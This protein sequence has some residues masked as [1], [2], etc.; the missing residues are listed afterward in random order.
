MG[1]NIFQKTYAHLKRRNKKMLIN[2]S[3]STPN[4]KQEKIR[5]GQSYLYQT[6]GMES[7]V[8]E[9]VFYKKVSGSALNQ[10][11]LETLKRYPYLNTKLVEL[12]G[13][14]YI[15]QNEMSITA[16][17]T[18]KLAKL[19]HISCGYHLIDITYFDKTVYVSW[20]HALCDGKGIKPFIE[21][22]VYYYCKFKYRSKASAEN[23]RLS[24]SK[25]L[26]GETTEPNLNGYDYD[27]NKDTVQISRDAYAIPENIIEEHEVDYRY[28][29]DIPAN[30]FM[31]VCKENHATPVIL[32]SLLTSA[33]IATLYPDFDKPINANIAVDIREA[34]D[35]PNTFKNCVRSM[36][37]PFDRTF[38]TMSLQEQAEKQRALLNAQRDRDNCRKQANASLG[39]YEKLDSLPDYKEKQKV[40]GFFNGILLNT[41]IISYLGQIVLNENAQYVD[42]MYFYNSGV[43]GLGI[44]MLCCGNKFCLNF[45]QSFLSDKYVKAFCDELKRLGINYSASPAIP[46]ITPK[47]S[48]LNRN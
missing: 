40:M 34:L 27:T 26:D 45:K 39:L 11:L 16:R 37:L 18:Q 7:E 31:K 15:V 20:H 30:E 19:G 46:F 48:L 33:G 21:S 14:F 23:I 22:L 5:S 44:T 2:S 35:L 6:N 10:A 41:Y 1:N 47:D 4:E 12:D 36:P 8:M 28:E 25:L 17:R 42:K 3:G 38:L 43:A 9:I 32:I 29:I 24:D 13:D